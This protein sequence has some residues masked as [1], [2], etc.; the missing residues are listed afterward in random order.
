MA[1]C[2]VESSDIG[3]LSRVLAVRIR[4]KN[5]QTPVR[6]LHLT[7]SA[8][9]EAR[10]IRYISFLQINE[11]YKSITSE[12]LDEINGDIEKQQQFTASLENAI[13]RSPNANAL[14]LVFFSF[15][16]PDGRIPT[17]RETEYLFDL[18]NM[19]SADVLVP[20]IVRGASGEAYLEFLDQFFTV[21]GT[22]TYEKGPDWVL[23]CSAS[24]PTLRRS[25]RIG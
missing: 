8:E 20:P 7:S 10:N 6:A 9:C 11:L 15:S 16:D 4:N 23:L 22:L 13:Q 19:P 24:S 14:D 17:R 21:Y 5:V 25:S 2:R 1:H 18:L 3:L 12:A